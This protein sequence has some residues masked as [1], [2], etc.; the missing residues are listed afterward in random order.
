VGGG[1]TGRGRPVGRVGEVIENSSG[2]PKRHGATGLTGL[3][4]A[5]HYSDVSSKANMEGCAAAKAARS[6]QTACTCPYL[7]QSTQGS[8]R[9]MASGHGGTREIQE[10]VNK[11]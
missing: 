5:R 1:L 3:R 8:S 6:E 9:D 10:G 2:V 7:W 11:K 4:Q